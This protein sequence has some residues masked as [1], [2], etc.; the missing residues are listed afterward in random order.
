L[1][2]EELKKG[3]TCKQSPGI[4]WIERAPA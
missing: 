2:N 3:G 4:I 1:E